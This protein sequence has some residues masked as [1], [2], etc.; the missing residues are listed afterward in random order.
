MENT[1]TRNGE[2]RLIPVSAVKEGFNYRR[3]YNAEKMASLRESIKL[4]GLLQP[5]TV[6]QLD[7]G[8][9][10]IAGGRRFKAFVEEFGPQSEIKAEI[11]VMT[12]A[13]ATAAMLAENNEREDPSVI[14]DAEGAARCRDRRSKRRGTHNADLS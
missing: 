2:S 3:R 7:D 5:V 12:D 11:R 1:T 8:Y 10:L 14:E 13:E 4:Q 9:Q 6:R